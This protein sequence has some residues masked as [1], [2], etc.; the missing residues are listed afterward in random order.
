M[1]RTRR[2]WRLRLAS[3]MLVLLL[4]ELGVRT[5]RDPRDA[6]FVFDWCTWDAR[7]RRALITPLQGP[8][9]PGILPTTTDGYRGRYSADLRPEGPLVVVAGAGHAFGQDIP[10]GAGLGEVLEERLRDA[11]HAAVVWNQAVPGS[12]V[13]FAERVQLPQW[14]ALRPDVVVLGHG[15]FNEALY[16]RIPEAHTLQPDRPLLNLALSSHLLQVVLLRLARWSGPPRTKVS[17]AVF[18]DATT[19]I[20]EALSAAGTSV[21]LLQQVVVN[22]DIPGVWRLSEHSAYRS[23]QA[24]VG[25][26]R[27][28]PVVDPLDAFSGPVESWFVDQEYY[29]EKAHSAV[30]DLLLPS[31]ASLVEGR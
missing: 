23:A 22:P 31:V 28:V 17:V 2:L 27:G 12:T 15:G 11:G 6:D 7:L 25:A 5:L 8:V 4:G 13:L 1:S 30:A 24:A 18:R 19:R 16:G 26:E 10:W 14:L 20:V 3:V 29:G 9:A 21:V